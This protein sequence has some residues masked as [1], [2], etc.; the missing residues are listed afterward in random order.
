MRMLALLLVLCFFAGIAWG[1]EQPPHIAAPAPLLLDTDFGSYVDDAFALAMLLAAPEVDLQGIT[2]SGGDCEDRAWMVGRMLT[3]ADRGKIPLAWGRDPQPGS[4]VREM[5]QYRYHPAVLFNRT[6]KPQQEDAA[7]LLATRL[8]ALPEGKTTL[9]AIGPLTNVA[10]LITKHPRSAQRLKRIVVLGGQLP[11]QEEPEWD[12]HQ[13]LP[14]AKTVL[15]SGLPL[16]LIPTGGAELALQEKIRTEFLNANT[17]LTQQIQLLLELTPKQPATLF[18]A[19]AAAVAI[20]DDFGTRVEK[21][22]AINERGNTLIVKEGKT[23]AK[24]VTRFD[25]ARF[26]Q[27]LLRATELGPATKPRQLKNFSRLVEQKGLPTRVHAFEDFETEIESRWWLTGIP[28]SEAPQG[29]QAMNSTLTLDF[30][31]LQGDL[32][33]MYSAVVFNPVPGPP[34]GSKTR[35]SFQYKLQGTDQLRVQLYSLSNGYHR[36]LALQNLP[37]DKW[38]TATVDM[39]DMRRPDGTG[40]PLAEDERIDD[41]QFYVAPTARVSIDHIILY[42]ASA[43]GETEPFPQRI[44]FTGLFDTGKQGKEW[45]GDFEI[46]EHAPPKRWKMAKSIPCGEVAETPELKGENW[47]RISFRG[48]RPV[49]RETNIRFQYLLRGSKEFTVELVNS[50]TKQSASQKVHCEAPEEWTTASLRMKLPD[51]FST[52]D[53]LRLILLSEAELSIDDLLVY[54]P[55]EH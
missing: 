1:E 44:V 39:T 10:R 16:V 29:K 45:P 51:G 47:L 11:S 54:E 46:V 34:M 32:K 31:D 4:E 48:Q 8:E 37:Q 42:E 35:L 40:G 15:E 5:F 22:I 9:L 33:S 36:Y 49:G 41:I 19:V 43:E 25:L 55:G 53:E 28:S 20:D 14:V 2:T 50:E 21:R 30:D 6:A 7:D 17:L 38:Q 52:A 12:F 3:M 23:N 26:E 13:D 24:V 27:L 18:D